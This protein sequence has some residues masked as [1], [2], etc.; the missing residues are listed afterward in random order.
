MDFGS[1][2][3]IFVPLCM[4]KMILWALLYMLCGQLYAQKQKVLHIKHPETGKEYTIKAGDKLQLAYHLDYYRQNPGKIN[5]NVLNLH[6]PKYGK[7]LYAKARVRHITDS[8]IVFMDNTHANFESLIGIRK[9]TTG[10]QV[11][12][13]LGVAV[14][15]YWVTVGTV[16]TLVIA[17]FE[18]TLAVPALL[19]TSVGIVPF[20]LNTN[21]IPPRFMA[22]WKMWVE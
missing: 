1:R 8:S 6:A 9:M 20:F 3:F 19:G 17:I 22:N 2:Y 11:L 16:A 13:A 21:R 18:P 4:R 14:G 5:A 12:R 7:V 10:K 15:V